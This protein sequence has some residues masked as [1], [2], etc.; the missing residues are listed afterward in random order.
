MKKNCKKKRKV[1]E[2]ICQKVLGILQASGKGR[3]AAVTV[4]DLSYTVFPKNP[5]RTD[6]RIRDACHDLRNVFGKRVYS[7]RSGMYIAATP[8]DINPYISDIKSRMGAL[9]EDLRAAE[10][11]LRNMELEAGDTLI[12]I[13]PVEHF[14][15]VNQSPFVPSFFGEPVK[16]KH[17]KQAWEF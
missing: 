15:A 16:K 5:S 4:W 7:G 1:N 14:Q 12:I 9:G 11:D 13:E 2:R 17:V 8:D 6:A 3:E 10:R